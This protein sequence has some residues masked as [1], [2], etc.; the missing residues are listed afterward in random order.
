MW[1]KQVDREEIASLREEHRGGSSLGIV[2][3]FYSRLVEEAE[4]FL[5]QETGGPGEAPSPVGYVLLLKRAHGGHSHVTLIE[6]HL[7]SAYQTRYEDVLDLVKEKHKPTAYLA[8]TDDCQFNATL[9]ARGHQVE[10]TA[11]VMLPERGDR[12]P[13]PGIGSPL[14]GSGTGG[15]GPGVEGDAPAGAGVGLAALTEEHLAVLNKLV[16]DGGAHAG[17]HVAHGHE[18]PA[19]RKGGHGHGTADPAA[20]SADLEALVRQG[21]NWVVLQAGSPVAVIARRDGGDGVHE[22][23]DFAVAQAGEEELALALGRAGEAVWSD[24]R[25]PAAVIDAS[26][27][28]RHRIFRE[29]DYYSAAAYMVFYDPEAGRPSVG[30]LSAD[31]LQAMIDEKEQFRLVDVLGEE[32]WKAGHIPGSE[33][34]DFKGLAREARRRFGAEEP[35]VLYCN[36]FT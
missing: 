5:I 23:L 36:G 19:G 7:T 25:R 8:R 9:L 21:R 35:I 3:G 29:A 13:L 26:E 10:A 15:T 28:A 27:T 17:E 22:L 4:T 18:D 34:I 20:A 30:A 33:W 31:Q 16:A 11:L 2:P 1:L 6:L 14:A 24:G 32:H 12:S